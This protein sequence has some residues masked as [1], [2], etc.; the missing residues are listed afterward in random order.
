M[1]LPCPWQNECVRKKVQISFEIHVIQRN[2]VS[3]LT[4]KHQSEKAGSPEEG[5]GNNIDPDVVK[6]V[7]GQLIQVTQS[8]GPTT[9]LNVISNKNVGNITKELN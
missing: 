5:G 3:D 1:R 6:I 7:W 8:S 4:L 2:Q 9:C